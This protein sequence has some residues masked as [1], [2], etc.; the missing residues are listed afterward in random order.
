MKEYRCLHTEISGETVI[1]R[2]RF[3]TTARPVSGAEEAEA[4]I[5][6]VSKKYSD[7]THNCYAYVANPEM[8]EMKFS[9]DGEPQGTA[10]QPMLEVLKKRGIAC[11]A[12]VVTRYFGGIKLGAGGLVSAYTKCVAD[13]LDRAD[14]RVKKPSVFFKVELSYQVYNALEK[15]L[16][17]GVWDISE[18]SYGNVVAFTAA[19]PAIY[20]D[21]AERELKD[22]SAGTASVIRLK[23]DYHSYKN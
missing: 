7:A 19:V 16:R 12:V 2:S 23:E 11:T 17:N 3:I 1:S 8:T 14:I 20:A 5:K 4:F 6:S 22:K 9:D 15:R 10:G 21:E 18:V 13:I